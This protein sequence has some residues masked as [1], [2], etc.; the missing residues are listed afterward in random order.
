MTKEEVLGS[1]TLLRVLP[2]LSLAT[3]DVLASDLERVVQELG[4]RHDENGLRHIAV[5][6]RSYHTEARNREDKLDS[7]LL[8]D[9]RS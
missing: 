8:I 3:V 9:T 4:K 1:A 7:E 5:A 6:V 2:V